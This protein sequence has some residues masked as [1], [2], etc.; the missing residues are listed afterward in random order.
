M[1]LIQ[2]KIGSGGRVNAVL[3]PPVEATYIARG[4]G[5]SEQLSEE[6]AA[7]FLATYRSF[8]LETR[9]EGATALEAGLT[10]YLARNYPVSSDLSQVL[11]PTGGPYGEEVVFWLIYPVHVP[12]T[13]NLIAALPQYV[14]DDVPPERLIRIEVE[15]AR[16]RW[17]ADSQ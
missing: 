11:T 5:V 1:H 7:R 13:F 9:D 8:T 10:R 15:H 6:E 16:P 17:T 12:L 14:F 2:V 4:H 3:A